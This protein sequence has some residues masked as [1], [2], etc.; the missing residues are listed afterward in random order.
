MK[1]EA[2]DARGR[3]DWQ[4]MNWIRQEK[5]LAIYLRDGLSCVWCGIAIEDQDSTILTL[6]HLTPHSRGGSNNERNLVTACKRCNSSRGARSVHKFAAVVAAYLNHS[7]DPAAI[8]K[9]VRATAKRAL[10]ISTAKAMIAR[11]NE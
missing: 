5:R 4:G 10:D 6:D 11:R 9:H 1:S 3:G 7:A 8:E 2:Q